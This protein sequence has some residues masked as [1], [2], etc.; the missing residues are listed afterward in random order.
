MGWEFAALLVGAL[1]LSVLL[2][3]WQQGRYARSVNAMVS[4]HRGDGR[5]LVTGRGL[6]KLRGTIVMLVVDDPADEVVAAR[7]LR[8]STIFA[9]AKPASA[10][11]GP[12]STLPERA[13]D[14]QTGK[15]IE[16]ALN[17]LKATRARV[18]DNKVSVPS[19]PAGSVKRKVQR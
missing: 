10:L 4:E 11:L 14:K 6:G 13:D 9:T 16:M 8:G 17:Q 3:I 7:V 2:G 18:R 5:L 19:R 12:L 1:L 15:A